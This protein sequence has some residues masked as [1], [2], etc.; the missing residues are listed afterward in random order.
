MLYSELMCGAYV[1]ANI[2]QEAKLSSLPVFVKLASRLIRK[3]LSSKFIKVASARVSASCLL[4]HRWSVDERSWCRLFV[5]S[6]RTDFTIGCSDN[7]IFNHY[8]FLQRFVDVDC[9][10]VAQTVVTAMDDQR[11]Q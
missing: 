2:Q 7:A 8:M 10:K 6:D 5:Y 11:C 3:H 1:L 4:R 9:L